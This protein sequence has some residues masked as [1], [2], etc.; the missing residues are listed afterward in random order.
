MKSEELE[1][2]SEELKSKAYEA[3]QLE[4]L[5][6]RAER[7]EGYITDILGMIGEVDIQEPHGWLSE[8]MY[9]LVREIESKLEAL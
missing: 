8:I 7:A 3:E 2:K 1:R 5:L 4:Q 9:E 6:E